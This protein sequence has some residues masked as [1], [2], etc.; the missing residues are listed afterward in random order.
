MSL[1][2][3]LVILAISAFTALFV[4]LPLCSGQTEQRPRTAVITLD[5]SPQP[6]SAGA[7]LVCT[8]SMNSAEAELPIR[9]RV[10]AGKIIKGQGTP[11]VTLDTTGLEDQ[12]LTAIMELGDKGCIRVFSYTAHVK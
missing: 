4:A 1:L 3:K 12:S 11:S 7:P 10:T 8:A 6:V 9:W 5:C 2:T